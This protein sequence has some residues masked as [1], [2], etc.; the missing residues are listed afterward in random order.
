MSQGLAR[1][2]AVIAL[3]FL[4][5]LPAASQAHTATVDD[6]TVPRTP[7]GKPDLQGVW[8]SGTL[9]DLE[10]PEE[11]AGRAFLT[12][13]DVA[14]LEKDAAEEK[15]ISLS[16]DFVEVTDS[17]GAPLAQDGVGTYNPNILTEGPGLLRP[18]GPR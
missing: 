3:V 10:R 9:T 8:T 2:L 13:E 12:D 17:N 14:A 1:C 11:Y 7:D 5:P 15:A 16:Q 18:S 6:A 4:L